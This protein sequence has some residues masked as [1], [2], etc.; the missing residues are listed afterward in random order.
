MIITCHHLHVQKFTWCLSTCMHVKVAQSRPALCNPMDIQSMG[1]SR[2]EYCSSLLQGIFPTHG[3]NPDL[4][5]CR[6]LYTSWTTRKVPGVIRVCLHAQYVLKCLKKGQG[7]LVTCG[8]GSRMGMRKGD[9]FTFNF[10]RIFTKYIH[11]VLNYV[12]WI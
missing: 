3:S 1:F 9:L 6:I 4:P 2:P 5:H 11:E 10:I 7:T 8:L 12:I